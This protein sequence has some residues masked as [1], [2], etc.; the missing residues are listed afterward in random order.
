VKL[1]IADKLA[2]IYT[3]AGSMRKTAAL[4][5]L[6]HQQVSRILH[7]AAIGESVESYERRSEIAEAVDVALEIHKDLARGVARDHRI[8]FNGAL[9]VFAERLPLR[10][11]AVFLDG[12]YLTSG[13][14][15]W[16]KE[17]IE[18]NDLKAQGRVRVKGLLGERVGALHLHWLSDKL[19]NAWIESNRKTG[20]YY[21]AS[22]GSVVNLKRYNSQAD[23]RAIARGSR[24]LSPRTKT[25]LAGR[26][27][28]KLAAKEGDQ[29]KRVFSPYVAMDPKFPPGLVSQS[30]DQTLQSRHA[31]ATGDPGTTYADQV[32]LQLDT[33]ESKN[34]G[35]SK[36]KARGPKPRRSQRTRARNPFSD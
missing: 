20:A 28:F 18:E 4:A 16:I 10:H 11:V 35:K 31:P 14:P 13:S 22:V 23:Q 27:A 33:R 32:L 9:P 15:E 3:S 1:S 24:G 7:R 12:Q 17:Y 5:G 26:E 8:P 34:A 2:L 25:A 29:L 30:I 6:S 36:S 19:R 21:S